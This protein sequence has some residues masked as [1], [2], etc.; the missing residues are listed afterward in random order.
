VL[1]VWQRQ[2]AKQVW[3]LLP[4]VSAIE[5]IV[6]QHDLWVVLALQPEAQALQQ[7]VLAAWQRQTARQVCLHC[8]CVSSQCSRMLRSLYP[9][10]WCA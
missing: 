1:A 4:I 6:V 9:T 7:A 2:T 8:L 5:L 3:L 10:R